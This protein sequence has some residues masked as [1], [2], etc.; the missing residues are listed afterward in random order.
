MGCSNRLRTDE[1]Y[2]MSLET[3][4]DIDLQVH[5]LSVAGC[6]GPRNFWTS[7]RIGSSSLPLFSS[8]VSSQ[9]VRGPN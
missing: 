7:S 3:L 5:R 2:L 8:C 4:S 1:G 6:K 9:H